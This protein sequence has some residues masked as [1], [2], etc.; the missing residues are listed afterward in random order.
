MKGLLISEDVN[1]SERRNKP[2]VIWKWNPK[3]P[4]VML[5]RQSKRESQLLLPL[6]ICRQKGP[7]IENRKNWRISSLM[8]SALSP[9]Y[10]IVYVKL[11][12]FLSLYLSSSHILLFLFTIRLCMYLHDSS[13]TFLVKLSSTTCTDVLSHTT[14]RT[15]R[16]V[17]FYYLKR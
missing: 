5:T 4:H 14:R 11:N 12:L 17:Y 7:S 13:Y 15:N 8:L 9:S 16:P 2:G 3:I 10:E 6:K 1:R